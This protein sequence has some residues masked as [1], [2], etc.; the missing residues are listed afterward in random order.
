[1]A[2]PRATSRDPEEWARA[3]E[4]ARE[5]R[6]LTAHEVAQTIAAQVEEL[7]V[8]GDMMGGRALLAQRLRQLA[9][10]E[11]QGDL[12]VVRASLMD[13]AVAA[14]SWVASLDFTPPSGTPVDNSVII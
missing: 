9:Q 13:L 14:G 8:E 1:M 10:A 5:T 2:R 7:I 3:T 6:T 11:R 4:G 12:T